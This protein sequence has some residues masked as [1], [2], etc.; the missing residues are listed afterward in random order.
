M[1]QVKS[2]VIDKGSWYSI[3]QRTN[4]KTGKQYYLLKTHEQNSKET[5]VRYSRLEELKQELVLS[6]LT[7]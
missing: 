3:T 5:T 2:E 7:K 1:S 6:I 4:K